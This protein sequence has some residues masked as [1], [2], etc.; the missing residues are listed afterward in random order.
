LIHKG[1]WERLGGFD[2]RYFLYGE[3]VDLCLRARRGGATP[4]FISAAGHLHHGGGSS[5][6]EQRLIAIL[7]GKATL[8]KTYAKPAALARSALLAGVAIR[9]S[10]AKV[11]GRGHVWRTAWRQRESWRD[12]HQSVL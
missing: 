9:A 12:G 11:I 4:M 2:E 1:L 5:T 3:D 8:Y 6:P 10:A 7:R